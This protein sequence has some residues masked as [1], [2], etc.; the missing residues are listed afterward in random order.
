MIISNSRNWK[1]SKSGEPSYFQGKYPYRREAENDK[2]C[3]KRA[4]AFRE[5]HGSWQNIRMA[6]EE[7]QRHGQDGWPTGGK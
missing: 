1:W 6:P 5:T 2:Q 3:G 7:V 4:K